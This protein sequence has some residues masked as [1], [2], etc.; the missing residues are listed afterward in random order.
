MRAD[1][2]VKIENIGMIFHSPEGET[3]ALKEFSLDIYPGEFI[4][5]VGPSGCGKST[6]LNIVAGLIQPT[7]GVVVIGG[8]KVLGPT[9]MVG[10]MPQSDQLFEWR[11]IW[12]NVQ[13]GRAHV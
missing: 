13:I 12:K 9:S 4:S 1:P 7:D 2:L 8:K 3:V 10:Y 6:L 11:S 5:L